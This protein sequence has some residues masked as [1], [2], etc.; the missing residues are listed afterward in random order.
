MLGHDKETADD[1]EQDE[2]LL[3]PSA[4][5]VLPRLALFIHGSFLMAAERLLT[6]LARS[7]HEF[8]A[9]WYD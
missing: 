8:T 3:H 9:L 6:G 1:G 7:S 5:Y 2:Y 4:C